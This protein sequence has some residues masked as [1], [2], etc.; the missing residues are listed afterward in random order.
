MP[1]FQRPKSVNLLFGL[2]V[3]LLTPLALPT[4]TDAQDYFNNRPVRDVQT[5]SFNLAERLGLQGDCTSD[6]DDLG[7]DDLGCESLIRDCASAQG[8]NTR[9]PYIAG[10]LGVSF[11]N[12]TIDE[13]EIVND[14]LFTAGG[15]L[16]LQY[17]R[18]NGSIRAEIEARGR[19]NQF[20]DL[21]Q[22]GVL[23]LIEAENIWSTTVNV[24]R[25]FCVNDRLSVYGGGGIGAGGYDNVFTV[26][27]PGGTIDVND[28]ST[29]FAWQVGAGATYD[30][31][32]RV[33][34]DL[35][36]RFF[37]MGGSTATGISN[38]DLGGSS[39]VRDEFSYDS[40]LSASELVL[41]LRI[42]DPFKGLKRR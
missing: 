1:R 2:V 36:Y 32:C 13:D 19:D 26:R 12:L 16:G 42:Y 23:A 3:Y 14:N 6:C 35:G 11:A 33:S 28:S 17:E 18:G 4:E 27:G 10:I 41:S 15:A 25:D 40:Q 34:L 21:S 22:A 29:N 24:W 30:I 20:E 5:V 7:C 38:I 39:F 8:C 9:R 31:N 37:S